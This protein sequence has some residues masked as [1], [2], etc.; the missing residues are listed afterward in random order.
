MELLIEACDS[1]GFDSLEEMFE[2]AVCDS[3]SPG[4]CKKCGYTVEI[5]PDATDGWCEKCKKNSVVS[6]LVLGGII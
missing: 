2:S 4:I 1:F 3:V 6:V 5:E